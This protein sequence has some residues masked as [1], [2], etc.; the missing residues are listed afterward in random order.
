MISRDHNKREN[1]YSPVFLFLKTVVMYKV[2]FFLFLIL[3]GKAQ[4]QGEGNVWVFGDG[5]GLDFNSGSPVPITSSFKEPMGGFASICDA[6]GQLLFYSD[7]FLIWNRDHELMP[8]QTG[9]VPGYTSLPPGSGNASPYLMPFYGGRA[10]QTTAIARMPASPERYYVFSL[11][12]LGQLLYSVVDMT[13]N[14]GKG[15]I[16]QGKMSRPVAGGL[17]EKIALVNGCNNIWV[18]TR[19]RDVNEYRAFEINDTGI[20]RTPVVSPVGHYP[21]AWYRQGHM[22]FSPDRSKM[23]VVCRAYSAWYHLLPPFYYVG[24]LEVFDF[25]PKTGQLSQGYMLGED[26]SHLYYGVCFSPDNSKLYATF[27][28]GTPYQ[29]G[30]LLQFDLSQGSPAAIAASATAIYSEPSYTFAREQLADIKMGSDG[31]LYFGRHQQVYMHCISLPNQAGAACNVLLHHLY[32]STQ[33]SWNLPNENAFIPLPDSV[34]KTKPVFVCFADSALL[35]AEEG[36]MYRWDDGGTGK[37]RTVKKEGVY[38]VHYI[39]DQCEYQTDRFLVRF[40]K[41]PM[42]GPASYS[43][44]GSYKGKLWISTAPDD[45]THFMYSWED[46][47][48]NLLR[49]GISSNGD[50]LKGIDTGVYFIKVSASYGCDTVLT[51]QVHSLPVPE[52]TFNMDTTGCLDVPVRF[53]YAGSAPVMKWDF[54]D[55]YFSNDKYPVHAYRSTGHYEVKLVVKNLEGCMDSL[56]REIDVTAL[57]LQLTADKYLV[58]REE[59]VLLESSADDS[60]TVLAWEPANEVSDPHAFIQLLRVT[61]TTVYLVKGI[62]ASGCTDTASVL[63]SVRPDVFMPTAFSPNGDGRNDFFRPVSTGPVKVRYF[64][65]YNRYGEKVFSAGGANAVQGWDGTYKGVPQPLGVYYYQ[66]NIETVPGETLFLKGDIT[67]LR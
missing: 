1:V 26:S 31:R 50:T 59:Q 47:A 45:T 44:P 36:K 56:T 52:A 41:T 62:S 3:S 32:F 55:G 43:C 16:V 57:N 65:I 35:S 64:E 49:Q 10:F 6:G 8:E 19:A 15:G 21:L 63:V 53:A 37:D 30:E 42:I 24:G 18:M 7:G 48:G 2:F 27:Q 22:K 9:G 11:T 51:A 67:L 60:Y 61:A 38:T 33:L 46:A 25:D 14:G 66:I 23:A 17:A 58:S 20:V 28:H 54:G 4:A 13:M 29:A 39:N 40:I 5:S 12:T 34:Y